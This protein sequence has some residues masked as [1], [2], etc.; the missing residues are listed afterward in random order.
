MMSMT[1]EEIAEAESKA[2]AEKAKAEEEAANANLSEEEKE[3]KKKA[4]EEHSKEIDYEAE[5]AEERKKREDAENAAAD[6]AYKLR[7][8]RRAEEGEIEDE[9]EKEEKPLT[10]KDLQSFERR[11]IERNEKT[12]QESKALEIVRANTSSEAEAQLALLK[13]RDVKSSG[14]LEKDILFAI[15]G[16]NYKKIVAK[17]SELKRALNSKENAYNNSASTQIDGLPKVEPKLPV[18]SPLKEYKYM[19]NGVYSKKLKSGKI[20]FKNTKALPGSPKMWVE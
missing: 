9:I 5:L 14:D 7:E 8:K 3:A 11:I 4:E 1:K 19:G 6:L 17:N 2:A 13:W 20:L 12:N 18:N 15:G 10:I 16:I